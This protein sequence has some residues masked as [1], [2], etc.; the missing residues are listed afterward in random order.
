MSRGL[1]GRGSRGRGVAHERLRVQQ[2]PNLRCHR[3][4]VIRDARRRDN[5]ERIPGGDGQ[6]HG[7]LV[8]LGETEGITAPR[9]SRC[10]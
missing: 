8:L 2:A 4:G 7:K 10:P 5:P 9:P 6:L 3:L 1:I